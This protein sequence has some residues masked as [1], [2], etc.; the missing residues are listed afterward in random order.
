MY[1]H[2]G[3]AF[4]KSIFNNDCMKLFLM[5]LRFSILFAALLPA[6]ALAQSPDSRV[7][8]CLDQPAGDNFM[9]GTKVV[10]GRVG[11]FVNREDE[12]KPA[13]G[14]NVTFTL[15]VLRP[16]AT[17]GAVY[18]ISIRNAA[19][20][21]VYQSEDSQPRFDFRFDECGVRYEITVTASV[22]S[23]RGNDGACSWSRHFYIRP[24]CNTRTCNCDQPAGGKNTGTSINLNLEGKLVCGAATATRRTYTFQYKLKNKTACRMVIESVTVVGQTITTA[25]LAIIAGAETTSFNTGISTPLAQAPP[26]GSSVNVVVRYKVNERTCTATLKIPYETCR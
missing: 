11:V 13:Q 5:T 23:P 20:V 19:G 6:A 25:S 26:T 16:R 21:V 22:K 17:C 12:L 15:P 3:V 9:G 14:E 7:C 4:L 24:N 10:Y 1:A 18:A 2:M 8:Y